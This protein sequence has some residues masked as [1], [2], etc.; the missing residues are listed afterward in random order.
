MAPPAPAF[1]FCSD[2]GTKNTGTAKFCSGCGTTLLSPATQATP[3]KAPAPTQPRAA[4]PA[5]PATPWYR[6]LPSDVRLDWARE[7]LALPGSLRQV[8][9]LDGDPKQPNSFLNRTRPALR[10]QCR[11]GPGEWFTK[12]AYEVTLEV[13]FKNKI[14]EIG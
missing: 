5:A 2:C 6:K 9:R 13:L 4:T 1:K 12:G 14:G 10:A 3:T 7:A 11:P 8:D